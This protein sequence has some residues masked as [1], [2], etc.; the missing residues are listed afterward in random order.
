MRGSY[1]VSLVLAGGCAIHGGIRTEQV[2]TGHGTVTTRGAGA[3]EVSAAPGG[4]GMPLPRGTYDFELRIGVPRAQLVDWK[5]TCTGVEERQG[6]VGQAFEDYKE[7]RLAQLTREREQQ[8]KIYA[9]AVT[10]PPPN[11]VVVARPPVARVVTPIGRVDVQPVVV[12]EPSAQ[13]NVDVEVPPVTELPPGDHGQGT[14]PARVRVVMP[15]DGVCAITALADDPGVNAFYSVT[16][17]RDLGVEAAERKQVVYVGAVTMRG[18]LTERLVAY[19]A[20]PL[21]KQRRLDAE[22]R[23]RADAEARRGAELAR[24]REV[25]LR[26]DEERRLQREAER[27]QRE[28]AEAAKRREREVELRERWLL[29]QEQAERA[30]ELAYAV[31]WEAEAPAR[32]AADLL[33]Y[34]KEVSIRWRLTLIAWLVTHGHADPDRRGRIARARAQR[35]QELQAGLRIKLEIERTER[36]RL[37]RIRMEQDRKELERQREADRIAREERARTQRLQEQR[38]QEQRAERENREA[39]ERARRERAATELAELELRRARA[40]TRIRQT[41]VG[42]L[43]GYGAKLRP[44]MPE[45]RIENPGPAPF[46]GAQWAAGRWEW[47][48]LRTEWQWRGGGWRDTTRFGRTGGE[49]VVTNTVVVEPAPTVVV[50]PPVVT[51]VVSTPV[52]VTPAVVIEVGRPGYQPRPSYQR[53]RPTARPYQPRPSAQRPAPRRP[54]PAQ[55]P[56]SDDDKRRR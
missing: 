55:A 38:E 16:R 29:E 41:V 11:V 53:P 2:G 3:S 46:D 42:T 8:A 14:F 48:S 9:R 27:S 1:L 17:Q 13:V 32:A 50:E 20:D 56:Q 36:E 33:I 7:H 35:E 40:A 43:I 24:Q 28:A 23:A 19:G 30:Q 47:N 45:L 5:V 39:I 22:A 26:V 37:I 52:V 15:A 34:Q 31:A 54:A 49:A 6:Q 51:T 44:P 25:E 4:G 10:Q 12:R 21:A 18:R